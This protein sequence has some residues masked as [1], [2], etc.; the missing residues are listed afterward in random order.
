MEIAEE[1]ETIHTDVLVI[2]SGMAG[3]RAAIEARRSGLEVLLVDKSLLGRASSSIYAGGLG[4]EILPKHLPYHGAVKGKKFADYFNGTIEEVFDKMLEEGV[5]IGWGYPYID[6]QRILMTVA[7]DYKLRQEELRDFGVEDP[8]SQHFIGRPVSM[9]VPI[10]L[11]MVEYFKKMGGAT[12]EKTVI[13]D[14]IRQ[15]DRVVGVIGFKMANQRMVAILA[16]ATIMASGGC[17]QVYKRTYSPTRITGD[18]YAMAYR[19]GAELWEM[20]LVAFCNWTIAEPKCPQ[21]WIPFSYGRVSGK[22]RNALGEPFFEKYAK[23]NGWLGPKATLNDNDVMDKRYGKPLTELD[24]YFWIAVSKEVREG[25]GLDGAVYLDL[26]DVPDERWRYENDGIAALNEMRNFDWKKKPLRISPAAEKQAGGIL[27]DEYFKS[28]LEG[29]YA[30][31]E[32]GPGVSL[33]FCIVSGACSGRYASWYAKDTPPVELRDE[34]RK[35]IEEKGREA[36]ALLNRKRTEAGDPRRIK[37]AI[38]ETMW[39]YVGTLRTENELAKGLEELERIEK[40]RL[41]HLYAREMRSL[42]EAYEVNN[43]VVVS[44]MIAES[45]RL[46]TESRG[47]HQRLDYPHEDNVNWL[48]NVVLEASE[49]G[50]RLSTKPVNLIWQRP[51]E[52][53]MKGGKN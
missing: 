41:P 11:P 2:G 34:D 6:N 20:E 44:K 31:G 19:A 4:L 37:Q 49:G 51:P 25:R 36:R 21:W 24:H 15:K 22:L 7:V 14:L 48:K 27:T 45:A 46:R 38:K 16:K 52:S 40:E 3:L 50:M 17:A 12:M 39:T 42:R 32:A 10:I 13:T 26:R 30:A 8:Y 43:M 47:L 29:F 33:P 1:I 5:S 18:G 23:E 53:R 9:G 35:W 28:S